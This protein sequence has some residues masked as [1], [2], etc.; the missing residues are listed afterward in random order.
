MDDP[1]RL[2]DEPG[3]SSVGRSLLASARADAPSARSRTRVARRLGV[4]AVLV[5]GA[6]AGGEAGAIA[7]TWKLA[8]VLLALG[9]VVGLALWQS[10]P[11]DHPEPAATRAVPAPPPVHGV[12]RGAETPAPRVAPEPTIT[13]S[14]PPAPVPTELPAAPRTSAPPG[15]AHARPVSRLAPTGAAR[16]AGPSADE[17]PVVPA[18]PAPPTQPDRSSVEHGPGGSLSPE[19][20][21]GARAPAPGE[22]S[23]TEPMPPAPTVAPA[24][25]AGLA[26]PPAPEVTGPSRLAAE[27]ALVDRA[28]TRLATGDAAAALAAIA[29]Y[30]QRFPGGDL[31]AEADVVTIEAMIAQQDVA[32][33]RSL[34]AAFLARFPRSPHAQRIRSLLD[35]LPK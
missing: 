1:R 26:A 22:A 14:A 30:H 5:A 28:R 2:I 13:A 12:G 11:V 19:N 24:D 20:S 10:P 8:A 33:A 32:R 7:A 18:P 6:G 9:S 27:V 3:G 16:S 31:D 34:G 17:S 29:E 35:R 4:A 23:V 15:P 25:P 21:S